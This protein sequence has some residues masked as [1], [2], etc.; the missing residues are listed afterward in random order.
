M[1]EVTIATVQFDTT[2]EPETN[3]RK[4]LEFCEKAARR[5]VQIICFP[6]FWVCDNPT[7]GFFERLVP[8]AEP[9]PGPT[10]DLLCKKAKELQMYI[11]PGTVLEK[12]EDGHYYNTSG[13]IGPDGTLIARIRKDHPENAS[14]KAEVDFGIVPGPGEY[15][16]FETDL[17]RIG[18]PID[19]D[20][21][22][23]EVP[24]IMGLK[25]AEILFTPMCWDAT[26]HECITL[27][28]FASSSVSDAYMVISNRT[29]L[30]K[31]RLGGSGI[32][33]L[34]DYVARVPNLNE[35]L[36]VATV[37]LDKVQARREEARTRYPFWRR[38]ETYG[39]LLD[40]EAETVLR[41]PAK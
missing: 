14:G 41:G 32:I 1:R 30:E 28:G 37:D 29:S 38:P 27:Y 2:P 40:Q 34:R 3:R 8:L 20:I 7:V 18:V 9:V 39:L 13:L 23:P 10:F 5:G 26:V 15:P 16:V 21:C 35:D 36:A 4:G 22:A 25:G 12:G 19:M 6:E 11:V 33:W 31:R 24:R 17:G